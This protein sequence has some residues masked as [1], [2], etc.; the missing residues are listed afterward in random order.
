MATIERSKV[1]IAG[2][3]LTASDLN[4][5]FNIIHTAVNGNL[6]EANIGTLNGQIT[7]AVS[8]NVGAI[9]IAKTGTGV[10]DLITLDNDGTGDSIDINNSSTGSGVDITTASSA[11]GING[12][13]TGSGNM[14]ALD[15]DGT[16]DAINIDNS[17]TGT[18]ISCVS[19]GSGAVLEVTS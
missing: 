11:V 13:A 19:T 14:I 17:S 8:T 10:G 1:W 16:G 7:W 15:N 4:G 18:C 2:D 5:E 9:N 6:D 3:V 12:T